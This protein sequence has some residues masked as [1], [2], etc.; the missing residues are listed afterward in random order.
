[1]PVAIVERQ[2]PFPFR[3]RKSSSLTPMILLNCG[4]VGS[5]QAFFC[6]LVFIAFTMVG[7]LPGFFLFKRILA[8]GG[9]NDTCFFK[10]KGDMKFDGL[11]LDVDGTIWNTTAVVARAWNTA[12]EKYF[13]EVKR[14]DSEILK[15][16]FGKT[17]DVIADNL[18][19]SLDREQK[20]F[21]IARCADEEQK[22]L[23]EN[24][25][26]LTYPN[27]IETIK[28]ISQKIPVF[29]V[30]NCQSG[31]IEVVMKKNSIEKYIADFECFGNTGLEKSENISLLVKRNNL[32]SAVYVGDTQGDCDSCEKARVPFI[33]ASYGFGKIEKGT[34]LC[35]ISDFGEL[36]N[37]IL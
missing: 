37:I 34:G 8:R 19:P 9:C 33:W 30:S 15:G 24:E 17:M 36:K 20:N 7:K 1:M 13:P 29:I 28:N 10:S 26:D 18:F 6:P 16:Q 22:T 21:L 3:T 12:I 35:S 5:C 11:I 32:K 31:Y 27:V 23:L 2:Y 14:V 4:K 25:E